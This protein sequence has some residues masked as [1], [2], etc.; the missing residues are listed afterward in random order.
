MGKPPSYLFLPTSTI[1]T[2]RPAFPR[3]L[4]QELF[5]TMAY[6]TPLFLS[7]TKVHSTAPHTHAQAC[8]QN[9]VAIYMATGF[10]HGL[11]PTYR[12]KPN[13]AV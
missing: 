2:P 8:P 5:S 13:L 1:S 6:S 4:T 11:T 10:L 7:G 9:T 3:N 12:R